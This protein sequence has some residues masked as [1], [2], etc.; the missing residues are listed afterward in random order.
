MDEKKYVE[1]QK[2]IAEAEFKV[3]V[4][5]NIKTY[6]KNAVIVFFE[7]HGLGLI[8]VVVLWSTDE[9]N[10][11]RGFSILRYSNPD[12]ADDYEEFDYAVEEVDKLT[13]ALQKI[14]ELCE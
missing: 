1:I 12:D 14:K 3:L 10:P 13:A 5:S 9:Y 6:D 11:G 7:Q 4:E 2:E 8:E